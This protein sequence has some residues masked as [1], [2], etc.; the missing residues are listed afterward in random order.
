MVDRKAGSAT[1]PGRA[2]PLGCRLGETSAHNRQIQHLQDRKGVVWPAL[3]TASVPLLAAYSGYASGA[4]TCCWRWYFSPP[5]DSCSAGVNRYN[6]ASVEL[7]GLGRVCRIRISPGSLAQPD[8]SYAGG[9]RV[10]DGKRVVLGRSQCSR[11]HAH[12]VCT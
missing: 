1:W 10:G 11:S 3:R 6:V 12:S 8:R 7:K 2:P 4:W 9:E 5:D